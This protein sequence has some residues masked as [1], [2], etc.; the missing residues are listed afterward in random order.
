MPCTSLSN[1][2]F[3]RHSGPK[4]GGHLEHVTGATRSCPNTPIQMLRISIKRVA[5]LQPL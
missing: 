5:H 1:L 2:K 4:A 3:Y